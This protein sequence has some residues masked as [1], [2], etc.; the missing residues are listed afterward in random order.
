MRAGVTQQQYHFAGMG[1]AVA[2]NADVDVLILARAHNSV[3]CRHDVGLSAPHT[4]TG[5]EEQ[6]RTRV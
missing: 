2:E 4:L 6:Q 3:H 1:C 5:S